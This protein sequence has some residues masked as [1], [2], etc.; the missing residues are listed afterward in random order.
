MHAPLLMNHQKYLMRLAYEDYCVEG[1][2]VVLWCIHKLD[3][4]SGQLMQ[5]K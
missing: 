3:F 5:Q 4:L 1:L 2:G